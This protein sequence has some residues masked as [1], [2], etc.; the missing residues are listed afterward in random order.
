MHAKP[1]LL[2][3]CVCLDE[4]KALGACIQKC[5]K[6]FCSL[7]ECGGWLR[8]TFGLFSPRW[9]ANPELSTVARLFLNCEMKLHIFVLRFVFFF[10]ST[11]KDLR[12]GL[13]FCPVNSIKSLGQY[14]YVQDRAGDTFFPIAS[15]GLAEHAQFFDV[16][17]IA[18]SAWLPPSSDLLCAPCRW[19]CFLQEARMLCWCSAAVQSRIWF[20]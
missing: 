4:G 16:P 3:G 19:T 1:E 15:P 14:L 8:V 9:G 10:H 12:P 6:L 5:S 11:G 18:V 13:L 17:R 20:L 2:Q 7:V